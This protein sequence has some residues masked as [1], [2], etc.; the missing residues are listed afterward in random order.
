MAEK[1]ERAQREEKI[2]QFWKENK[3]FE[4]TLEKKAPKGDFVFYEG[5]PTA[6]GKPAIHHLES[7]AFKDAIPRYKTMRG[8]HVPRK[9]GWDTHGLPVELEVEKI[10]GLKSKKEIEKYGIAKFNK[11]CRASAQK[12]VNDW[13]KFTDRIGYW[14]NLD[15]AYFTYDSS[16][17][18]VVWSILARVEKRKLLYKDYK[19]VPWCPRCGTV[20]SSHELAQGYKDVKDLSVYAKFKVVGEENTYFLAWTTTPWTLSGNVALAIGEKISYVKIKVGE[21]IFI[22]AESKLSIIATEYEII[23]NMKGKNL[24][25]LS[26]EPLYPFLLNENIRNSVS[27]KIYPADFVNTEEG[28]GI[29]HTAVMYGQDDFELG[30]KIGLPKYHLV[31]ESGHFKEETGFLAGKF[32][33]DEET[34]V[35]IIKDLAHRNL[36][37][38]KEKYEHSY[39]Y[40]WRCQ[41]PL[42]YYARDSW[43]IEMSRLRD[44]LVKANEKINWEPEHI[45]EG[46]FGEWLNGVRD[47][48]ISRE[49]YWGTPLPIWQNMD[50]SKRIVV[51]SIETLEKYT[52]TSG[53]KYF[54]MRHGESNNIVKGIP[55]MAGD[56]NNHLTEKGKDEAKYTAEKLKKE[57]INLIFS[58]PFLR[59]KETA[60]VVRQEL[61]L[62]E[63]AL[64]IDE[65]LH[66]VG[67]DEDGISLRRRTGGFIFDV[68]KRYKGKN[69]L[70]VSHGMPLW[71]LQRVAI[72]ER[73]DD[74]TANSQHH[75]AEVR[76]IS[77]IAFPH[78]DN[79]ELDLHRPYIDNIILVKDGEE[80]RRV[81]EVLDVWFDSG[82]MPFAQN[83]KDILYPADF[84][85]EAIDQTRGWFYTLHAIGTLM[86]R[87]LAYKNVICLGHLLDKDG[88]KMSKSV[89]N[90]VDPWEEIDRHGVDA[91]RF[92]MYS[93][94][95]PGESKNF[96]SLTVGEINRRV[97]NT[98]DNIYEFY[99]LYRDKKLEAIGS[100]SRVNH[101]LDKWILARLNE[102]TALSTSRLDE[103]KLLEPVRA[104]KDF[105]DDLS[106]WY[107]R[108]SRERIKGGNME[109]K[110]TLYFVLKALSKLLAPFTPFIAEDLYQ[111]LRIG[112]DPI[113]VHLEEWPDAQKVD[114]RVLTDMSSIRAIASLALEARSN[115]N[116]KVRQPLQKL[117]ARV[118]KLGLGYLELIKDEVNVKE[119]VDKDIDGVELDAVL[120]PELVE[121][122]KVRDAIRVIQDMRKEKGL[123]PGEKIVYEVLEADKE[124]F[125]KYKED[126][127]KATNIK[128]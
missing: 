31:D 101:V 103:Y 15:D 71:I 63:K 23:D 102:L 70:I 93:V 44:E 107:L 124:L 49:R 14:V 24:V 111:K 66:E 125:T 52:K 86:E 1:S 42:I 18:E 13:A 47:W 32:V 105:V 51:N 72:G 59:T 45:R 92:W 65:R 48:A 78:N 16:Y 75:L 113:S 27:H 83:P 34:T 85:S 41:T 104:I 46:R 58:S 122:G 80:Y 19:V 29:V 11:E 119:V 61:G 37:F 54:A 94:N 74:F 99:N 64:I 57:K 12:Y 53:N 118:K 108:R 9:A 112:N 30:T 26:Y 50:G 56:P 79:F 90:A 116:I 8:F 5:P 40:C 25:G 114:D 100:K 87:G 60:S 68:E 28:T 84:I 2:L 33:K 77:V 95:Q 126:I 109:A 69:I 20:L 73:S 17:I 38:K 121:E 10:L 82:S 117:E 127:E 110:Q 55:D 4:K 128:F 97:F 22:L 62:D 115:A 106:T 98:L 6:N 89:G 39:P 67:P 43:Y 88:K 35:E 123:K 21:E 7:R 3:I 76:E 36:L 81:K 120:T 96:D 91:L